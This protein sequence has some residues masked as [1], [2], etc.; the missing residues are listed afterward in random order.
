VLVWGAPKT[1]DNTPNIRLYVRRHV[2]SIVSAA[3]HHNSYPIE[4]SAKTEAVDSSEW[5]SSGL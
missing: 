1:A 3:S 2:I 4:V 5:V